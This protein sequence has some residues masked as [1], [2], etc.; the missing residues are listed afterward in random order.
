M[1]PTPGAKETISRYEKLLV[2]LAASQVDFAVAGGVAIILN[3]YPRATL[4]VDILVDEAPDNIRRLIACLCQWGEGHARELSLDDFRPEEG[5]VRVIEDFEVD[6]FT[7]MRGKALNDFRPA[8]RQ[9]EM[10]SQKIPFLDPA[11]LIALKEGSWREKDQLDVAA[12]RQIL[13]RKS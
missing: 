9:V 10:Q 7:R 6:I 13:G 5:A 2:A 12:M 3:G 4:D 11:S 1:N 8:L